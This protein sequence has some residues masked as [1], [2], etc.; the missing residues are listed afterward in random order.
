MAVVGIA[1]KLAVVLGLGYLVTS[2]AIPWL[3]V[4]LARR[5]G[6]RAKFTP[7]TR[8]RVTRFKS[9]RRGYWSFRIITTLFVVSLF[10]E[11]LVSDKALVI[12]YDGKLAF[13]AVAITTRSSESSAA[14][15][16]SKAP[17]PAT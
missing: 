9:I 2:K 8:K 12:Y 4:K 5:L 13:P 16:G 3:Y 14:A 1:V 15:T 6:F 11:L 7:I 10:L 17:S